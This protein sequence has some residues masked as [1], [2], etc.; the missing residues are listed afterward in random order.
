MVCFVELSFLCVFVFLRTGSGVAIVFEYFLS[1]LTIYQWKRQAVKPSIIEWNHDM[2]DM[3][4]NLYIVTVFCPIL[5]NI[6]MTK[7]SHPSLLIYDIHC[8][9][10]KN[11]GVKLVIKKHVNQPQFDW[12]RVKTCA[13]KSVI[14]TSYFQ[15]TASYNVICNFYQVSLLSCFELDIEFGKANVIKSIKQ[16]ISTV[17]NISKMSHQGLGEVY[18]LNLRITIERGSLVL[19]NDVK[20]NK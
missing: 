1:P 2:N 5:A 6:L 14:S 3:V 11:I 20:S 18:S 8:G 4:Q 15:Q 9:I 16:V 12:Y 7:S 19:H 13:A 17:V 10:K